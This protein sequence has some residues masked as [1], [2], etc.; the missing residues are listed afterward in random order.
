MNSLLCN[1]AANQGT[2]D[3][4]MQNLSSEISEGSGVELGVIRIK[5][6]RDCE[7]E[8]ERIS[9]IRDSFG[10][11]SPRD[12]F[13]GIYNFFSAMQAANPKSLSEKERID[14]EKSVKAAKFASKKVAIWQTD[15]EVKV[16]SPFGPNSSGLSTSKSVDTRTLGGFNTHEDFDTGQEFDSVKIQQIKYLTGVLRDIG[17]M[18]KNTSFEQWSKA[19]CHK[20]KFFG[21]GLFLWMTDG[22]TSLNKQMGKGSETE[23]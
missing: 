14:M 20:T 3:Q 6:M 5:N 11:L 2:T 9:K 22:Y 10:D 17:K 16:P 23:N 7:T 12:S 15:F 19:T 8:Y 4:I 18:I 13:T 21:E 1:L